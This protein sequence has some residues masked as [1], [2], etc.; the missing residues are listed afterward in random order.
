M[1]DLIVYEI[2][3]YLETTVIVRVVNMTNLHIFTSDSR[4][5][6][7]VPSEKVLSK[8]SPHRY[9]ACRDVVARCVCPEESK[10]QWRDALRDSNPRRTNRSA[11]LLFFF[12]PLLESSDKCR[13]MSFIRRGKSLRAYPCEPEAKHENGQ[14]EERARTLHGTKSTGLV[15][16]HVAFQARRIIHTCLV[17]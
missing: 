17:T 4:A 1:Y 6:N 2:S 3:R 14:V 5:L 11:F 13:A 9:C 16:G 15:V 8:L 10:S 7:V 12:L